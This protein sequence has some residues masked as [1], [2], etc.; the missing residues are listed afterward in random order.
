MKAVKI[1]KILLI[2]IISSYKYGNTGLDSIA[3]RLR[4]N[5]NNVVD[6]RFYHNKE[7][8]EEITTD[9]LN[10]D[11]YDIY[12]FSVF[13]TN[14]CLFNKMAEIIKKNYKDTWIVMGGQFISMN[15]KE[16]IPECPYIDYFILGDGESPI[17]RLVEQ[18]RKYGKKTVCLD[19]NIAHRNDYCN[20]KINIE[21]EADRGIVYDYFDNDTYERNMQ[22]T[23]CMLTKSNV[24]TGNCSF[25]VSRKGKIKYI[26]AKSL[27]NKIEYLAR[28]YG[29]RK[30]FLC[31]DDIFDIDGIQNRERLI[32]FLS[33]IE[34]MN[35]NIVFSGFAKAKSIAN[36]E[37]F[38]ILKKM[39]KVGFHHLFVG[40]DTGNELDRKLYNKQSSL[41]EGKVAISILR[42]VGIAP[43]FGMI[44]FNPF[45]SMESIKEN[46]FYLKNIGSANYYHYGGLKV[47]LLQGTR[48]LQKTKE[49][50]LLKKNYSVLNT[51]A[52][53]Y[54]NSD[55]QEVCEF[56][57]NEFYEK[58]DL[59]KNQFNTLKNKFE[60]V[61]HMNVSVKN[62]KVIIDKYEEIERLELINFFEH[63]YVEN[64]IKLCEKLLPEFLDS[65]ERRTEGYKILIKE[66]DEI[67]K[68]I[69]LEK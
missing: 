42:N 35:I 26:N 66:L 10:M 8:L 13:E 1:L 28:V 38:E 60:L 14:Y 53:M 12:G 43:R 56:L 11:E 46:F 2:S 17:E 19:V 62:Y 48:L 69:P 65:M 49:H 39:S 9:L 20:K 41:E 3:Y 7:R 36:R 51:D 61:N 4:K 18:R 57:E 16:I 24:C 31:D 50:N 63:L 55:V 45:S 22:K 40:I 23:Y 33:L 68:S 27:V 30:F 6:M 29:I 25:C 32:E 59:I 44:Y 34:Q 64:N 15:Y 58:V 47:Q 37:N 67:Y 54:K 5:P 21:M 52:Y